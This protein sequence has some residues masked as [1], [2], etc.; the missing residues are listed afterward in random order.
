MFGDNPLKDKLLDDQYED[1]RDIGLEKAM[2]KKYQV[3][4]ENT[5]LKI[6]SKG[7]HKA[8][9]VSVNIFY[10]TSIIRMVD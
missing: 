3:R 7:I 5:E 8:V 2:V 4:P 10:F 6:R 1:I 9:V